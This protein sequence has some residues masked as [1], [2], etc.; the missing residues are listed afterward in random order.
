MSLETHKT[1]LFAGGCFWCMESAFDHIKG[2]TGAV[3]G[4]CGGYIKNPTYEQVS[5]GETG[6][7]ESVKVIFNPQQI[8]YDGLL[9]IF[10]HNID[11]FDERGQFC[12]KGPS[13]RSAV[14]YQDLEQKEKAEASKKHI[15]NILKQ[16]A[17]TEILAASPFY[18]AEEHHQQYH[19]KN[20]FRYKVFSYER[21]QRLEQIWGTMQVRTG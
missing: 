1:A 10:W 12:D 20:P 8:T 21:N 3:S 16:P 2:V 6:H 15:E 7:Y 4:Y 5:M 19:K 17:V 14:F 11:P 18:P 9:D 13:Y